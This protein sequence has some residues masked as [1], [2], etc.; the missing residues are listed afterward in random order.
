[1]AFLNLIP[2]EVFFPLKY[3]NNSKKK[4]DRKNSVFGEFYI[5]YR[6]HEKSFHI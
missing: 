2:H 1:M 5:I 3:L 4:M 6:R